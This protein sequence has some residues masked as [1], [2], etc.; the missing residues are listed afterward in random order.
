MRVFAL[1]TPNTQFFIIKVYLWIILDHELLQAEMNE[2]NRCTVLCPIEFGFLLYY[3]D[4][5]FHAKLV[6]GARIGVHFLAPG[7]D[8]DG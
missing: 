4:S 2:G 5:N 6:L 3:K 8:L 1:V 7:L